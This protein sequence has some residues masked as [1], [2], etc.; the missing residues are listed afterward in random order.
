M[1]QHWKRRIMNYSTTL[2]LA[3][4]LCCLFVS[5]ATWFVFLRP[6][7]RQTVS[8]VITRKLSSRPVYWQYPIGIRDGFWTPAQIPIAECYV[9][10]VQVEGRPVDAFYSLN[11][12]AAKAFE[13]G[14]RV[15]IVYEER[16]IAAIWQRVYVMDMRPAGKP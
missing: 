1:I 6:V 4:A 15:E 2:L 7:P 13:G 3:F 16:G 5:L 10:A 8:G 14:Q 12:T 11:T 9:F